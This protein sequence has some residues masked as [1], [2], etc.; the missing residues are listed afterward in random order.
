MMVH[1][2]LDIHL[3]TAS[4]SDQAAAGEL[5]RQEAAWQ[6]EQEQQA[7]PASGMPY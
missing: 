3:N 5:T 1:G 7:V 2:M 6:Q 4:A